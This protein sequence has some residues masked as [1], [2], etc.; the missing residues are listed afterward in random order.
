MKRRKDNKGKVLKDG[1]SQR[2]DGRYVYQYMD[3]TGKRKSVYD[4]DLNSLRKKEKA[5]QTLL[6]QN[7]GTKGCEITLNEQHEKVMRF[8]QNIKET[9]RNH[10]IC[11]WNVYI[12]DSNIGNMKLCDIK[13][14]H[15][16][17]LYV[18]LKKTHNLKYESLK[19]I[20]SI[21]SSCFTLAIKDDILFKNPVTGCLR[22]YFSDDKKQT[23]ALTRIQQERFLKF[24][25][26]TKPYDYFY[27]LYVFM[28]ETGLRIG[29]VAGLTWKKVDL[30]KREI[31][32]DQQ[33]SHINGKVF[34]NTPKTKK[35]IRVIPL[36]EA[37]FKAIVEQKRKNLRITHDIDGQDDFVFLSRRQRALSTNIQ[38]E[39]I[40]TVKAYNEQESKMS[41]I[42]GYEQI[43]M[44]RI[45]PHVFRHTACTRY[46]EDGMDIKVLQSIMGHSTLEMTM[47]VYNH[48]SNTRLIDE[49][50]R[51]RG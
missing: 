23:I 3:V 41:V 27:P 33:L 8:K 16:I 39:L 14:S 18:K 42:E 44:P 21:I 32:I 22:E 11:T 19:K 25:K 4:K 47:N 29:E 6:D 1:E 17:D 5:I 26:V 9:T 45:T 37:A 13:R 30:K 28:F 36:G 50:R 15:I 10:Y 20:E 24:V 2:K 48:V 38:K 40:K 12:R 31:L 34:I 51:L 49:M 35:S 43:F 7:I 46:A